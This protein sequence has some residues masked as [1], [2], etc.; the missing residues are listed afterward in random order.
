MKMQKLK[1]E[2]KDEVAIKGGPKLTPLPIFYHFQGF[3]STPLLMVFHS[4]IIVFF[5]T[6]IA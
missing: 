4:N 2:L 6:Q 5:V 3:W 1:S